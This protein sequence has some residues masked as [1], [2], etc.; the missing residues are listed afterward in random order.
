MSQHIMTVEHDLPS[1][2]WH[3]TEGSEPIDEQTPTFLA[4]VSAQIANFLK[5]IPFIK[6]STRNHQPFSKRFYEYVS[7][8]SKLAEFFLDSC[9]AKENR[10][11]FFLRELVATVR[12]FGTVL[13]EL[14]YLEIRASSFE[15]LRDDTQAFQ[16]VTEHIRANFDAL[17]C[18]TIEHCE[19]EA[20]MLGLTLPV[21]GLQDDDVPSFHLPGRLA[22]DMHGE[23]RQKDDNAIIKIATSFLEIAE[24]YTFL[25]F[26]R[27]FDPHDLVEMVPERVNEERLRTFEAAVHNLQAIYDTHIQYTSLEAND[28]R[29]QKLRGSISLALHLLE[30]ATTLVHFHERH[31][32]NSRH[33]TIYKQLQ[34]IIGSYQILDV[35]GNYALFYCTKFLQYGK[36]LSEEAVVEYAQVTSKRISI[37]IYRGFHVRP[38]TYIAKIVHRYGANVRMFLGDEV[39]DAGCVFDLFRANEEINMEKR[40]LISKKLL[41]SQ[42]LTAITE[43]SLPEVIK[44]ELKYLA[45]EHSLV[46]HQEILPE[47]LVIKCLDKD[48]LTPEDVRGAINQVIARLLAVGKIDILMPLS[49]IFIGDR[50]PLRDIEI[51]AQSGYGEDARGTNVPLP[52]EISYL[53]K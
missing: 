18:K 33:A 42:H 7:S 39:Y 25:G 10:A 32:R 6:I 38:S 52:K 28:I 1:V 53:Y 35:M 31:E 2:V 16:D 26:N 40:R 44:H 14:R 36:Q 46:I 9:G 13:Y 12:C 29:L 5:I 51:L 21:V 3:S 8:Q 41:S 30:I 49:V 20:K 23:E 47:D 43:D 11:W 15:S 17:L 37:P 48:E 22:N 27:V 24:E 4:L 45:N 34:E 50:R 19:R